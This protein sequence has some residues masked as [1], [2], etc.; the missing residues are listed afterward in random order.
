M[1]KAELEEAIDQLKAALDEH[2]ELLSK[3]S[4]LVNDIMPQIKHLIIQDFD[5]LNEV[6]M[7][8]TKLGYSSD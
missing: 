6:C 7:G 5:N 1:A 2:D 8:L 3:V 4:E